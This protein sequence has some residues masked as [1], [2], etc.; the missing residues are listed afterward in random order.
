MNENQLFSELN[1]HEIDSGIISNET[2]CKKGC[3]CEFICG[4]FFSLLLWILII[5]AIIYQNTPY[6]IF[7]SIFYFQYFYSELCSPTLKAL[8]SISNQKINTILERL[9]KGKPNLYLKCECYHN[10]Q[11]NAGQTTRTEEVI[12]HS[13]TINFNHISYRDI[14]GQ[15]IL[16]IDVSDLT[17]KYYIALEIIKKAYLS[18][19]NS[20]SHYYSLKNNIIEN[21]QDRDAYFI[22]YNDIDIEGLPNFYLIKLKDE[23][24][25]FIANG[26][27]YF[28]FTLLTLVEFYKIYVNSLILHQS[29]IIKKL[30]SISYDVNTDQRFNSF[31]PSF[32]IKHTNQHFQYNNTEINLLHEQINEINNDN[33]NVINVAHNENRNNQQ[34]NNN[35]E[36]E[37]K[38]E[39]LS[40]KADERNN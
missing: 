20:I 6:I 21:N 9:I 14:S 19:N 36:K 2:N 3:E 17:K 30:L 32:F 31:N 26:F 16:N 39:S 28:I 38:N 12:T 37:D 15:L 11:K 40:T 1:L 22:Y 35:Q 27:W 5:M 23:E 25:F 18:D 29:F 4:W 24:P 10:V 13:E 33:I 34:N 8:N 7:A